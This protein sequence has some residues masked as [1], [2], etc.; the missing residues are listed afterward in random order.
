M[1]FYDASLPKNFLRNL[2]SMRGGICLP[3]V[4][5]SRYPL[6]NKNGSYTISIVL[7]S[8]PIIE[9]IVSRPTGPPPNVVIIFLRIRFLKKT[10]IAIFILSIFSF[11]VN[12][13][14]SYLY[15][16]LILVYLIL[17]CLNFLFIIVILKLFF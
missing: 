12:I 16:L 14:K 17:H 4:V 11:K 7:L 9:A 1:K 5:F 6:R 8:S 10:L 2:A 13:Y 15:L 3:R